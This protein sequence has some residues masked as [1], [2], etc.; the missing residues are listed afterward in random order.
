MHDSGGL[1]VREVRLKHSSRLPMVGNVSGPEGRNIT[2]RWRKP[3]APVRA[4][5]K[6]LKGRHS[7]PVS[8]SG[9]PQRRKCCPVAHATGRRF[10]GPS[11]LTAVASTFQQ[12][13]FPY[14][15]VRF[16]TAGQFVNLSGREGEAPAEP[17]ARMQG[18]LNVAAQPELR[19]PGGTVF[20]DGPSSQPCRF[21]RQP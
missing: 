9:L 10:V 11:G 13:F 12:G 5:I 4:C 17:H 8:P 19:P 18:V 2:C 16:S 6:D 21:S 15:C 20:P 1:S 3:Q 7:V 14:E